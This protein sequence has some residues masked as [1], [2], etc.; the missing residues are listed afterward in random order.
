VAV[1]RDGDVAAGR[2]DTR[3]T[4]AH[5]ENDD[6]VLA[7]EQGQRQVRTTLADH[8]GAVRAA[9][10]SPDGRLVTASDDGN[11]VVWAA[12]RPVL[13]L[14]HDRPVRAIAISTDGERV[15]TACD[16]G[17]L[18]SWSLRAGALIGEWRHTVALGAIALS[19]T[20]DLVVALDDDGQVIVWRGAVQL[21]RRKRTESAAR[22]AAF[23]HDGTRLVVSGATDA[24]IFEVGRDAVATTPAVALDGP[25][26]DVRAVVFTGDDSRVIT[27][28][29]DGL[30]K[31]WDAANGKLIGIRNAHRTA[32]NSLAI[33][34]DGDTLWAGSESG[35]QGIVRA[36]DIRVETRSAAALAALLHQ[37]VP[38]R[39]DDDVVVRR[40]SEPRELDGQR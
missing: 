22:A 32:I 38:W 13:R 39:L 2:D 23:S 4:L 17:H 15:F 12:G 27:G 20:S 3:V 31:V 25:L 18:R 6:L 8:T 29:G 35:E 24:Q 36:W 10:F 26:Q 11:V 33:S 40:T 5:T 7:L 21:D 19:P 34:A 16:D 28:G 14:A 1:A 30:A 9:A 37:R